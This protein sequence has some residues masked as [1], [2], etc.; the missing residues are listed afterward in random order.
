PSTNNGPGM[1]TNDYNAYYSPDDNVLFNEEVM[2]ETTVQRNAGLDFTLFKA[3][4]MGSLDFYYNTTKDLLLESAI[5]PISGFDAQWDN[6]GST[7]NRGVELGLNAYI[8][9]KD[10]F[11]LSAN[12]NFGI[13]RSKIEELD[14]TKE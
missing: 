7:T 13:N 8:I 10:D 5:S 11:T 2:W 9:E 3:K 1:G 4:I 12:F 14:G 6:V